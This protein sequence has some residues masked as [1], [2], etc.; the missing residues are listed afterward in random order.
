MN[1]SRKRRLRLA[2]GLISTTWG[3][4]DDRRPHSRFRQELVLVYHCGYRHLGIRH[5]RLDAHHLA[6]A[7]H[8]DALRQSN[9][10]GEG[11]GKLDLGPGCQRRVHVKADATGAHIPGLGRQRCPGVAAVV[12]RNRQ[13]ERKSPGSTLFRLLNFLVHLSLVDTSMMGLI[14]WEPGVGSC[15][16]IWKPWL[17]SES[18]FESLESRAND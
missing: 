12:H 11:Q 10:R 5:A 18:D 7:A 15:N 14:G 9:F 2:L 6:P 3:R 8:A 17:G 13:P 1:S 4:A 16:L